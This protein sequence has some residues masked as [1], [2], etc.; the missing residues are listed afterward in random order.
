MK[1]KG[2]LLFLMVLTLLAGSLNAF[3]EDESDF[4]FLPG[5]NW[6]SSRYEE[7]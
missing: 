3:A 4:V 6:H 5:L 1:K 7:E 2:W